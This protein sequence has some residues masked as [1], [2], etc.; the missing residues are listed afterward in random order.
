MNGRTQE[1]RQTKRAQHVGP[2]RAGAC[3]CIGFA[4]LRRTELA[5]AGAAAGCGRPVLRRQQRRSDSRTCRSTQ[6]R[7]AAFNLAGSGCGTGSRR[8][9]RPNPAGW[10]QHLQLVR[11]D[12][13][14]NRRLS[15]QAA[16]PRLSSRR[17]AAAAVDENRNASPAIGLGGGSLAR[18]SG[19]PKR[20]SAQPSPAFGLVMPVFAPKVARQSVTYKKSPRG[21]VCLMGTKTKPTHAGGADCL[22]SGQVADLPPVTAT[23]I[24]TGKHHAP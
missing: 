18:Q 13:A 2:V 8:L 12:V 3:S 5:C 16:G 14:A 11:G 21:G 24:R 4:A 22:P 23:L 10:P 7:M 19:Y 15:W 20:N 17:P 1:A 9:H 6:A